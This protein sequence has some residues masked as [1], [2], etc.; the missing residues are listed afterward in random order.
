MLQPNRHVP[1]VT[2]CSFLKSIFSQTGF[3]AT[4]A[5]RAVPDICDQPNAT[6]DGNRTFGGQGGGFDTVTLGTSAYEAL[7]NRSVNFTLEISTREGVNSV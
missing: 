7:A 4:G 6:V 1:R 3:H 5:P 2:L